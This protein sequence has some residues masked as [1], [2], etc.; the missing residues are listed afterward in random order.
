MATT[1][2]DNFDFQNFYSATLTADITALTLTIPLDTVPAP[3]E[4]ILV[5][6]PDSASPEVIFYTAKGVSSITCASDGRGW[7]STTAASRLQG[8]TVIMAPVAYMLRM[9]KSGSLYDTTTTGYTN[10]G[11]SYSSSVYNGNRSYDV[12]YASTIAAKLSPGVRVRV[13]K[14]AVAPTQCTSLNGTTQYYSKATPNGMTFTDDFVVSVWVKISSYAGGMIVSRWNGSSGWYLFVNSNGTVT[15][16]GLNGGAG[17]FRSLQTYQSLPLNKW[18]HVTAQ[19]DMSTYTASATTMYAM[20]DGVDVP[21]VLATSG[22]NPTALVQAGNLEIGAGNGGGNPLAAK[23]AQPAVYSAKVTQAVIRATISQTLSGSET[24]LISAY[25]FNNSIND[26]NANAN[27]LTANGSAVATNADSP[28]GLDANGVPGIY[29][30]AIVTKTSTTVATLQVPEG[31]TIPTTGGVTSTFYSLGRTPYGFPGQV[32]RWTVI[33]ILRTDTVQAAPV[34]GTW[35]NTGVGQLTVPIGEWD[36]GYTAQIYAD[37]ASGQ[38]QISMTL[39]TSSS[40]ESDHQ[41]TGNLNIGPSTAGGAQITMSNNVSVSSTEV[42]YLSVS[43]QGGGGINNIYILAASTGGRGG[44]Q[45][46]A[47]CAYL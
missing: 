38:I 12:T 22:T 13:Q 35:Y 9:L 44:C 46:T 33:S 40:T 27:N 47:K 11:I 32:G 17:N 3:T 34:T 31:N 30:W 16:N 29:D 28:F 20:F 14:T 18:V 43:S 41:F 8:T 23:I 26:L 6:D 4:G 7:D 5:I 2:T 39:S 45:I 25:S 15:L 42:R 10:L 36:I 37:R 21:V 24:S 19:L 1:P